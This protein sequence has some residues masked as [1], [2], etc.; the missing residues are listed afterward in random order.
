MKQKIHVLGEEERASEILFGKVFHSSRWRR[1]RASQWKGE[2]GAVEGT[3]CPQSWETLSTQ[4]WN[5]GCV[6]KRN[7]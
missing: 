3:L 1:G 2:H 4:G 6:E 5:E 7:R